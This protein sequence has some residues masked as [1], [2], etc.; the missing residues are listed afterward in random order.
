MKTWF[1][2]GLTF[3]RRDSVWRAARCSFGQFATHYLRELDW[4]LGCAG[5]RDWKKGTSKIRQP[6]MIDTLLAD[7]DVKH[8][9]NILASLWPN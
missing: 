3:R 2:F 8:S 6:T 9:S 4:Y 7:F 1:Y 5:E